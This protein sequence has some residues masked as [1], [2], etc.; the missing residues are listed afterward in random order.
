MSP[1]SMSG[2]GK[3]TMPYPISELLAFVSLGLVQCWTS[4][5]LT[6]DK[7]ISLSSYSQNKAK[8][9]PALEQKLAEEAKA[10]EAPKPSTLK[11]RLSLSSSAKN[12]KAKIEKDEEKEEMK[13]REEASVDVKS[14]SPQ[15]ILQQESKVA[16]ERLG[17]E[18]KQILTGFYTAGGNKKQK[19]TVHN[20]ALQ[21]PSE[22]VDLV[23]DAIK[24]V[25]KDAFDGIDKNIK[26]PV[27]D[28]FVRPS[29]D[30]NMASNFLVTE[31]KPGVTGSTEITERKQN[32]V[33]AVPNKNGSMADEDGDV[34]MADV[35]EGKVNDESPESLVPTSNT[36]TTPLVTSLKDNNAVVKRKDSTP[37]DL[38]ASGTQKS[39]DVPSHNLPEKSCNPKQLPNRGTVKEDCHSTE[40]EHIDNVDDSSKNAHPDLLVNSTTEMSVPLSLQPE[41]AQETGSL[42]LKKI[43]ADGD[44]EMDENKEVVVSVPNQVN[45]QKQAE[46]A[47][48][49]SGSVDN[50]DEAPHSP[51]MATNSKNLDAPVSSTI[52]GSNQ[53]GSGPPDTKLSEPESTSVRALQDVTKSSQSVGTAIKGEDDT[54]N[55]TRSPNASKEEDKTTVNISSTDGPKNTLQDQDVTQSESDKK[56]SLPT[57]V[58]THST[59]PKAQME[60]KDVNF[61]IKTSSSV[62]PN[63]VAPKTSTMTQPSQPVTIPFATPSSLKSPVVHTTATKAQDNESDQNVPLTS[64]G[65]LKS[66]S[67]SASANISPVPSKLAPS[68]ES[69]DDIPE[70]Q[71][72]EPDIVPVGAYSR[73]LPE[74]PSISKAKKT[75]PLYGEQELTTKLPS[76]YDKNTASDVEK[77]L[78]PEWFN[79][80]AD[81][82]TESSY[83]E[84]REK[85]IDE[86]RQ[87]SSKYLT[88]TAV[89]RCVAGDAGS[90]MRLHEFLVTWGFINGSAIGDNAPLQVT[91]EAFDSNK[92]LWSP[93]TKNLLCLAV[94]RCSRKRKFDSESTERL[95][96]DWDAV[97][98]EVGNGATPEECYKIFLAT[99][100]SHIGD[101][102]N[103]KKLPP[104]ESN[105]QKSL[106]KDDFILE[107]IDGIQPNVAKAAIHAALNACDGDV[108]AAQNASVVG[109]IASKAAQRAREEES[110]TMRILEEILDLRMAK[111]EN[112]LSLL[113]DLEGMLDA[114]RMALELERRDLY[115]RRCRHWFNADSSL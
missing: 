105:N 24:E 72:T 55:I 90:I 89:R 48:L 12:E 92:R 15:P 29:L 95:E 82:R 100:F 101:G 61:P 1:S 28:S 46:S 67:N 110:T 50:L 99:D 66:E 49:K 37:K 86:A 16:P 104:E 27:I 102:D 2:V 34:K 98:K 44:V 65:A 45:S 18:S 42:T 64:K 56:A 36:S 51:E 70:L 106:A 93:E 43:D 75:I 26:L 71:M 94:T 58:N 84:T 76:W 47:M 11:I 88:W 22:A 20:G 63:A 14:T 13:D 7:S 39:G 79:N 23:R 73:A 9:Y 52:Q 54:G 87:S 114:E 60:K 3:V 53:S 62:I 6:F 80:S 19:M 108:N 30:P 68:I 10:R 111:L 113:D 107:L 40:T 21:P 81:H 41:K 33:D 85:I 69:D 74:N 5:F 96:I 103:D 38:Q 97:S 8:C 4:C 31:M 17:M 83:V 77:T 25:Q 78:L 112:R 35:G 91:D 57:P 32:N 59:E 115:T 109:I